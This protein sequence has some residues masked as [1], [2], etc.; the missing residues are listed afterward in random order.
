[1]ESS[2]KSILD[3][4]R[5]KPEWQSPDPAVRAAAVLRVPS[6]ERE[7]VSSFAADPDPRVR[8]AAIKKIHDIALLSRL[9]GEDLDG[10]V[11]EEA[12]DAL[13][14]LAIHAKEAAVGEATLQGLSQPKHLLAV[15]RSAADAATRRAA[16]AKLTDAKALAAAAREAPDAELR[17]S[18]VARLEDPSLL[19]SLA[20]WSEHKPVALVAVDKLE[21]QAALE[22][23][24]G[25]AKSS[26]ASRRARSR[27]DAQTQDAPASAAGSFRAAAPPEDD[28]EREA[29]E[30]K[31]GALRAEQEAK[32]HA[33]AERERLCEKL[34][35]AAAEL[36][37][38]AMDEA[39]GAWEGL[40]PLH[41]SEAEELQR[42][43]DAALE[44]CRGR[45]SAFEAVAAVRAQLGEIVAEA[46]SL[47][48]A[49][50]LAAA[51]AG[52]AVLKK[53]WQEVVIP[54][55]AAED[56]RARFEAAA[57]RLS[58]RET[59]ALQE[60]AAKEKEH[61]Q[62]LQALAERLAK[63][64]SAE[65]LTLREVDRAM[66]EAK[67]ALEHMGPLPTKR[68]RDTLHARLEAA[69]K[70][71]YPRLQ[72]LRADA[73]WKRWAN[74]SVQEEL[75]ARALA[76]R[77]ETNLD[78]AAQSLRDLDARWRA[79]AEVDKAK[80]EELWKHFKAARDEV[81]A[82][83]DAH[84]EKRGLEF[85]EHLKAKE[86]LAARAEAL[87]ESTDWLN[88]AD[89]LKK[90]QAEWKAVGP[91]A[92]GPG[93][94]VWER[95]RK[96]CDHFF[97]RREEDLKQRKDEWAANEA[98][99]RA[100]IERAEALAPS[101][102]WEAAAAE[103]KKLQ[104]EWKAVGPVKKSRSEA[105]WQRFR[106]ACDAFFERYK[107]RDQINLEKSQAER[108]ALV[109]ALEALLPGPGAE[110][111]TPDGLAAKVSE[112]HS[113]WRQGGALP[114]EQA[115]LG[116]RFKQALFALVAAFP[117]GFKGSDLDPKAAL[118]KL[119]KLCAKV[120]ALVPAAANPGMSLAEQLTDALATNTLGGRGEAEARRRAV[121]EEVRGAREAVARLPP[122]PGPEGEALRERFEAAARR[123][124]GEK[125]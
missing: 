76:L 2:L 71:L 78:R 9:A 70:A 94:A 85:A 121:A 14:V 105:L 106:A 60:Q 99:K 64:R 16:L 52:I 65:S 97:T 109:V 34:E 66:R 103:I 51:R 25:R 7:L 67:D 118:K 15:V 45:V 124:V 58:E 18:A 115:T 36:A 40:A 95:F 114:R 28:A 1:V 83:V 119:E 82:K 100:L 91:T 39:R 23:V 96:A 48:A 5:G 68:D 3:R 88:T 47:G 31:L 22:A 120:A 113:A 101:T 117:E 56:L 46:E 104:A 21:D 87:Q 24:V 80:G 90:L 26:A 54:P 73:E 13:V 53:K 74:E 12:A 59:K 112:L 110:G 33:I 27:L 10:S 107:R 49:V 43:F 62:Q 19:L 89:E 122:V 41:G 98:K 108:E 38:E 123:A 11:R 4:F 29:Y 116:D 72:E 6:E 93:Q 44:V 35:D 111:S 81:K 86:E 69:R 42:R 37:Q 17:L 92:H 84:F 79:A 63:L 55:G 50:D 61:V 57:Q 32:E 75:V 8:R 30:E 20:Q 102:E 125:A 77:A